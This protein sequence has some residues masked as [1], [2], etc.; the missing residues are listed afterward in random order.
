MRNTAKDARNAHFQELVDKDAEIRSSLATSIEA[1][2]ASGDRIGRAF[3]MVAMAL[4]SK[5]LGA[6]AVRE[7]F[8]APTPA[9]RAA[10][11]ALAA[12]P[13]R[14]D[15]GM[16]LL[17]KRIS[18]AR[19]RSFFVS[20]FRQVRRDFATLRQFADVSTRAGN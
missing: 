3:E 16:D 2:T 18:L 13:A 6:D 7:L 1:R 14:G 11:A 10:P 17:H 15:N 4:L 12:P 20:L 19:T 8:A 5:T 9:A